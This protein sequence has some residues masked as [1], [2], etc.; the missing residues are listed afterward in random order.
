MSESVLTTR[1]TTP[2]GQSIDVGSASTARVVTLDQ[3]APL[4]RIV[5][6]T[7]GSPSCTGALVTAQALAVLH[8][9]HVTVASVF[10]PRVPYPSPAAASAR[11][12]IARSD[13]V[14]AGQQLVAVRH[15]VAALGS[16]TGQWSLEFVAGQ[17]GH[18]I[19]EIA[20]T[21]QADLLV[22][23]LGRENPGERGLGDRG[24]MAI[25]AST[26]IPVLAADPSFRGRARHVLLAVG[27]DDSALQAVRL[28]ERVLPPPERVSLVHVSAHG[29]SEA[30]REIGV[31]FGAI[32]RALGSWGGTEIDRWVLT[33]DPI[34]QVLVFAAER[35]VDLVLG[36]LHGESF[37]ERS[38]IRNM[39]LWLIGIGTRSVFLVPYRPR[40]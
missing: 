2:R 16:S 34:E 18:R 38:I 5:V 23:G 7:T 22:I 4:R 10:H 12:A 28:A 15:Q 8:R 37:A 36:G 33:G 24:G 9:A 6:A 31:R 32:H 25:A 29:D 26:R 11:P 17:A 21:D 35:N 27:H 3:G 14:E 20:R 40:S 13:H 1:P 30:A 39:V 19:N